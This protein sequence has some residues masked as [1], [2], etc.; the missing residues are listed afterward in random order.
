MTDTVRLEQ[1]ADF[2]RLLGRV[3]A[4]AVHQQLRVGSHR[5][6][7][8]GHDRL[9]P[10]RPF[11]LVVPTFPSDAELERGIAMRVAQ[12]KETIGLRLRRDIAFHAGGINGEEA[13][14]SAQKLADALALELA[15]QI[16]ERRVEAAHR[17]AEIGAGKLV[18]AHRHD[19]HEPGDIES[20]LPER[21]WRTT[22]ATMTERLHGIGGAQN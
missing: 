18:L 13:R 2:N 10:A 11:I 20:V 4:V 22:R 3:T 9:G 6:A 15:A 21:P 16:P 8:G 1:P 12:T 7:H 5:F 17:P 14:L 19:I